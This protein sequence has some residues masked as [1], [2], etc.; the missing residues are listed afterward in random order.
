MSEYMEFEVE[1]PENCMEAGAIL[2]PVFMDSD[3]KLVSEAHFEGGLSQ[4]VIMGI[5][6]TIMV[7]L[8]MDEYED[9]DE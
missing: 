9:A 6:Q 5:L 3:G 2:I 7:K 8:A 1:I 4:Y